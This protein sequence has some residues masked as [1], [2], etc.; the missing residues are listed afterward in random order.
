MPKNGLFPFCVGGPNGF[1][2]DV[3]WKSQPAG[4]PLILITAFNNPKAV[5]FGGKRLLEQA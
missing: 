3:D 4:A 2:L 5:N 1:R